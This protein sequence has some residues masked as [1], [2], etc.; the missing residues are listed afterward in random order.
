MEVLMNL[1]ARVFVVFCTLPV[2]EYAHALVA[3]KLGDDTARLKGRLTLSPLAHIDLIGALMIFLVGFGYAKPVPVNPRRFKNQRGGMA[4]TAL[5]GPVANLIMALI[6]LFV[7]NACAFFYAIN[8]VLFLK[9]SSLFFVYAAL[10]NVNLAVFNLIPI[11]PLDGS[12]IASL[13]IPSKY[14]FK[15]MQYER[16]IILVVFALIIFGV[17]DT[18]ISWLTTKIM[19]GFDYITGLPFAALMR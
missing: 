18:P 11:P 13:L 9:V 6:F 19:T 8:S 10:I 1:L 16:Y 7:S 2:H 5:A 15:I 12:R 17:L 4:L 14:Y 3:T